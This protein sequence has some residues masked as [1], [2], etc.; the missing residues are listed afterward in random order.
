MQDGAHLHQ[1]DYKGAANQLWL[2]EAD[3]EGYYK[4]KSQLSGKCLDI[5]GISGE[6]GSRLQIWEDVDGDN[7][8]WTF[9]EIKTART[10]AKPAAKKPAAKK[11]AA[12]KPAAKA[13]E[14]AATTQTV[15]P[16]NA[17][18]A[19]SKRGRRKKAVAAAQ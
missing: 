10:A 6:N 7:Q 3:E 14:V 12:A 8:K 2:L 15:T 11:A 9:A 18:M 16:E 17:E 19:T 5:A 4:I 13:K 1:W